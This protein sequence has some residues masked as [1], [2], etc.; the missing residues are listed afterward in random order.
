MHI[1]YGRIKNVYSQC[2]DR[3]PAENFSDEDW[4]EVLQVNLNTVFTLTRDVGRHM[5]ESR[6]GVS[7]EEPKPEGAA[8]SNPRGRGKIINV[9]SLVSFQG[10]ITVVAYS[11]AKHGVYGITKTFSNEWASKV[12]A[13][14]DIHGHPSCDADSSLS[15]CDRASMSMLLLQATLLPI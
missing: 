3:T 5:L 12:C 13:G 6:G 2:S 14:Q 1:P 11:A 8:D 9:A 4:D 7:G 10:G 15:H